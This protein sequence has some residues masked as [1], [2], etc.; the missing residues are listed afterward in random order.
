MLLPPISDMLREIKVQALSIKSN[1]LLI[2]KEIEGTRM[3]EIVKKSLKMRKIE[4]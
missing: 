3:R 4:L 1:L 2:Y